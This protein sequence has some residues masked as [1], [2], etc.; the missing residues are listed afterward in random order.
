[1]QLISVGGLMQLS[2]PGVFSTTQFS[3][4]Y[5]TILFSREV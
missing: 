5:N 3:G 1:M 4:G 2:V